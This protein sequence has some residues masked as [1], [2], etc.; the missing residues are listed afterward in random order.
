MLIVYTIGSAAF[1]TRSPLAT[2]DASPVAA[3]GHSADFNRGL[4][5]ILTGVTASATST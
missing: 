3:A 1:A 5:W 4:R 2:D